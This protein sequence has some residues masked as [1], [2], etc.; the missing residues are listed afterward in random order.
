MGT[1]LLFWEYLMEERKDM[2]AGEGTKQNIIKR[3]TEGTLV[4]GG[5]VP[6]KEMWAF[7]A[8]I[9][10]QNVAYG[11]VSGWLFYYLTNV[12]YI[13]PIFVGVITGFSRIFDAVN[14]LGIG[15][16]MDRIRFKS[17]EKLRPYL[18]ITPA[19][20]GILLALMF[21]NPGIENQTM[22]FVYI[23]IIYLFWDIAYTF[24]DIAMWGMT[25]LISTVPGERDSVAQWARVGGMVGGWLPGLIPLMIGAL[26]VLGITKKT[27]FM[28]LGI[29]Y[30][31]G[32]MMASLLTHKAKERVVSVVKEKEPFLKSLKL[33]FE[34]KTVMLILLGAILQNVMFTVPAI[35][36]F[37][38]KVTVNM[39]GMVINGA[40][41][42]FIF[43]IVSNLPAAFAMPFATKIAKKLGGMKSILIWANILNVISRVAAF[44]VGYQGVRMVF[45]IILLAGGTVFNSTVG[46][47]STALWCDSIDEMEVKTGQ[48]AEAMTFSMQNLSAKAT[49]GLSMI[50]SGITLTLLKFT[51]ELHEAGQPLSPEFNKWIWPIFILGPALGSIAYII[52]VM[53]VPFNKHRRVEVQRIL[54]ERRAAAERAEAETLAEETPEA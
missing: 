10:G 6:K 7:S 15:A 34:N 41:F 1:R 9:A 20:I 53:F 36:F 8:G 33:V 48:R 46:I 21:I 23:L 16:V 32:G 44:A 19:I 25:S 35:Y 28:I 49:S 4:Q 17:G 2:P 52:P 18:K 38:Y 13:A 31:F 11:L 45:V 47:A 29:I 40:T 30:G 42:Y 24:Q 12:M 37:E 54:E 39:F 50:V 43:G 26:D 22:K 5:Q 51:P 14:D 27:M 3:L